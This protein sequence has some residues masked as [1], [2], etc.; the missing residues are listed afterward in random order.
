MEARGVEPLSEK[1]LMLITNELWR[2][3]KNSHAYHTLFFE[4]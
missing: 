3:G 2:P 1:I 4:N